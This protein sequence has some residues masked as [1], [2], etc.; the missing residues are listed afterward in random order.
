M[1]ASGTISGKG[2]LGSAGGDGLLPPLPNLTREVEVGKETWLQVTY[3]SLAGCHMAHLARLQ[4]RPETTRL[5]HRGALLEG[6]GYPIA[7]QM[8]PGRGIQTHDEGNR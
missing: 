3:R 6:G 2:V 1:L 4:S 8:P 7:A 5:M